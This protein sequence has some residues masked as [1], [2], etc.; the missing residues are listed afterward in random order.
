MTKFRKLLVALVVAAGTVGATAA[1]ALAAEWDHHRDF[2]GHEWRAHDWRGHH[3][4][5]Y[6]AYPAPYAYAP[7]YG[8]G[9]AAPVYG[10][11]PSYGYGYGAPPPVAYAPPALSFNLRLPIR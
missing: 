4:A 2:R 5:F 1:P 7:S 6:P 10:Y 9:Y 8:Y 3:R 11:A